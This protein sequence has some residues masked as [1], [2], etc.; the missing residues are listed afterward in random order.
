MKKYFYTLLVALSFVPAFVLAQSAAQST[1]FSLA[2]AI[3]YATKHNANYLN[4]D[5]DIKMNE[6]RRNETRAI[7]L[8]QISGSFD[9]KDY[10]ELPTSLL[11]GQFFGG[12]PGTYVPVKFGVPYN[13]TAGLSVSQLIFSSDYMMA[14]L[15]SKH[16]KALSDKA[17]V[18]TK[19]ETVVNVT[20]AYYTALMTRERL[21]T[22]DANLVRLKK[23]FDDT[24]ALNTNGFVEKIDLDRIELAYNNL[25]TEKEKME[26]IV[27]VTETLLKFQMGYDLKQPIKLTDEIKADQLQ[28]IDLLT[29]TKI[30]YEARSEYSLMQTQQE[31]NTLE[32][33]RYQ[34]QHL[35]S[36]V[37]YGSY[38][39]QAQ[40]AKF[41]IFDANQK[42]FP[43]GIVGAT[44]NVP[45]FNGGTKYYK[46]QQAR[47]NILKTTNTMNNLKL[48]IDMEANISSVNYK[49]AFASLLTQKRN[50]EL[51][52]NIFDT[53]KKKYDAGVGSNIEV[54][55]AETSLKESETNYLSAMFDLLM[56]K[57]DLDK[58]LGNI[59]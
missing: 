44:I 27:G 42:W 4:A 51:A 55:T 14:L 58:A 50:R 2:A 37:A 39:K 16:V 12:L 5:L 59:K 21:K 31:L 11:P 52:Q 1:D 18:R 13:A 20:K 48:A 30:N 32:L 43:I 24:K 36:I 49:N 3:D 19:T 53:A 34:Y 25:M 38:S 17:L 15:S 23:L 54:I 35:P 46:I 45:I 57:I 26:R 22:L 28:D 6:Y 47:V 9:V 29:D 40:R 56:A 8:P 33:K 41:D 10:F 7:G